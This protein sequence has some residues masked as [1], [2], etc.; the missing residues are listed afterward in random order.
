MNIDYARVVALLDVIAKAAEHGTA[1]VM[2][3][4]GEAGREIKALAAELGKVQAERKEAEEAKRAEEEAEAARRAKQ[5]PIE[6]VPRDASGNIIQ[7]PRA[8]P[9]N[10][11]EPDHDPNSPTSTLRRP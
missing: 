9:A 8:I 4:A 3:I 5:A 11:V 7:P 10:Q 1:D 6:S 2:V